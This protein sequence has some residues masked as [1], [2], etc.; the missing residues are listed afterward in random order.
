LDAI[1][2]IFNASIRENEIALKL[3]IL[4]QEH[5]PLHN[6][7]VEADVYWDVTMRLSVRTFRSG[8]SSWT[9]TSSKFGCLA[10]RHLFIH[11]FI[12][13]FHSVS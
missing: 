11:S 12:H 1:L 6:A 13:S 5:D 10:T 2:E 9:A 8:I 4:V 3:D 7:T